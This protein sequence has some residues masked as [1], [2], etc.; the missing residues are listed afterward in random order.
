MI[1]GFRVVPFYARLRSIKKGPPHNFEDLIG[2]ANRFS[3]RVLKTRAL[4]MA[5]SI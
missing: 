4:S 5:S 1:W 3:K 2:S